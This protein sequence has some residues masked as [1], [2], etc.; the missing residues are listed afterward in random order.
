MK[1]W[2]IMLYHAKMHNMHKTVNSAWD[3]SE[4]ECIFLASSE[5]NSGPAAGLAADCLCA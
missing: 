2:P 4:A 3:I 5:F 1:V